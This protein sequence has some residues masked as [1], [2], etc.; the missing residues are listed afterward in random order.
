VTQPIP[1]DLDQAVITAGLAL[2]N[3]ELAEE[4]DAQVIAEAQAAYEAA[5]AARWGA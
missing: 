3:A 4:R 2:V 5:M 1:T